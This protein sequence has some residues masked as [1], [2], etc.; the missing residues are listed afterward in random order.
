LIKRRLTILGLT[1]LTTLVAVADALL[2][3]SV[4]EAQSVLLPPT[5]KQVESFGI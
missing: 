2:S 5:E 4:Y 3:P 1:A